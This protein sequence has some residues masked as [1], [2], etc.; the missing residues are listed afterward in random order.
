ML[1]GVSEP[2]GEFDPGVVEIA[3]ISDG[4]GMG[5]APDAGDKSGIRVYGLHAGQ[6]SGRLGRCFGVR[7]LHGLYWAISTGAAFEAPSSPFLPASSALT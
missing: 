2:V 4:T 1:D 7:P 3:V 5:N 6:A